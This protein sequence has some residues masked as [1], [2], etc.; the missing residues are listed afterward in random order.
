MLGTA[1]REQTETGLPSGQAG[2]EKGFPRVTVDL[3]IWS[4]WLK[5]HASITT[6][7]IQPRDGEVK[8]HLYELNPEDEKGID[9]GG[10]GWGAGK[11]LHME[12]R[13]GPKPGGARKRGA[14]IRERRIGGKGG[15]CRLQRELY[16]ERNRKPWQGGSIR[17]RPELGDLVLEC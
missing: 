13:R 1:Y 11:S 12:G 9:L 4:P 15:P 10:L 2:G 3:I 17:R 7:L 8:L 16:P 5:N 6:E 14:G